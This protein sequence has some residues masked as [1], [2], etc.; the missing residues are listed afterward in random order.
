MLIPLMAPARVSWALATLAVS[1]SVLLAPSPCA[2]Q[3]GWAQSVP[4]E[5]VLGFQPRTPEEAAHPPRAFPGFAPL[6]PIAQRAEALA[7]GVGPGAV[8]TAWAPPGLSLHSLVHDSR[9]GVFYI[10]GGV[11]VLDP[12][13]LVWRYEPGPGTC[14]P[15][16]TRPGGAGAVFAGAVYDSLRDRVLVASL[17]SGGL[18]VDALELPDLGWAR[19]WSTPEGGY[20]FDGVRPAGMAIDTRRDQ[21]A[22]LGLWDP[23]SLAQRIIRIPLSNPG[24]WMTLWSHGAVLPPIAPNG[25]AVYDEVRDRFFVVFDENWHSTWPGTGQRLSSLW[26]VNASGVPVWAAVPLGPAWGRGSPRD[27]VRDRVTD[28]LIVVDEYAGAWSISPEDGSATRLDDGNAEPA[29]T[30]T[31]RFGIALAFDPVTRRLH[32]HGGQE[33]AQ[34]L[35]MFLSLPVEPSGAPPVGWTSEAPG[36]AGSR[37]FHSLLFDPAG[38][39]M[40][41]VGGSTFSSDYY[42]MPPTAVHPL[43]ASKGWQHVEPAGPP[44]RGRSLGS[45]YVLDR[46]RNSVLA[47]G[48]QQFG[49]GLLGDTLWS[50]PLSGGRWQMVLTHGPKPPARRWAQ[51]FFDA[52]NGRFILFGGDDLHAYLDDAWELR[53]GPTPT[54]RPLGVGGAPAGPYEAIFPDEWR[55][56][57][58]AISTRAYRPVSRV[59]LEPDSI[60]FTPVPTVGDMPNIAWHMAGFCFDP[61]RQRLVGFLRKGIDDV[62]FTDLFEVRLGPSV[63][64]SQLPTSGLVPY[65]RGFIATTFDPGG[66]R[67]FLYGGYDDNEDYRGDTWQ[68]Q[69][70]DYVTPVAISLASATADAAGAHLRWRLGAAFATADVERARDGIA[71]E[72]LGNARAIGAGD[73]SFDDPGLAPGE[74]AAYRLRVLA[75]SEV[76]V[77]EPAW[78]TAPAGAAAS[79]SLR[80][81]APAPGGAPRVLLSSAPGVEARLSLHDVSGRRLEAVSLAGGTS[82]YAFARRPAPGLYFAELAQRGDRRVARIVVTP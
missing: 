10:V 31:T 61:F 66:N 75:G 82:A 46:D 27:L 51:F 21:L 1:L 5:V 57:A 40:V 17:S 24:A 32:A 33:L 74:S 19:V 47:Y 11:A 80:V 49:S 42:A 39:R 23:D 45:A 25:A 63:A 22:L 52:M 50:L 36:S 70:L 68:L 28:R 15:I 81:L 8:W 6:E 76:I 3:F 12:Q 34:A 41:V 62:H 16:A 37:W 59:V 64:W 48:G 54:W 2:A 55:G 18:A 58:W 7:A 53:M 44:W 35:P 20:P 77:S 60:V 30:Y 14:T 4:P 78:V 29:G 72:P 69:L 65:N 71:W 73:L 56:G 26:S 38:N 43:D 9:R 13:G 67:M 79:L